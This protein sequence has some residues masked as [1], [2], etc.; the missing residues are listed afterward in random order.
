MKQ[1]GIIANRAGLSKKISR[2]SPFARALYL[3]AIP[4]RDDLGRTDGD[5]ETFKWLNCPSW[6]EPVEE[7]EKAIHEMLKVKLAIRYT[8]NGQCVLEFHKHD[9]FQIFRTDLYRRASYPNKSGEKE[10]LE[11]DKD[12]GKWV[13]RNESKRIGTKRARTEQNRTNKNRT[14][15]Q[16]FETFWQAYPK[17]EGKKAAFRCWKSLLKESIKPSDLL[18]AAENYSAY[19]EKRKFENRYIKLASTF[20]GPDRWYEDFV[21]KTPDDEPFTEPVCATCYKWHTDE[22]PHRDENPAADQRCDSYE[23]GEK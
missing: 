23:R 15:T 17:H 1:G 13:K 10:V 14:Y 7:I 12:A 5:S 8:V 3:V 2:L 9:E 16:E 22:C 6:P 19:C 4:Q 21:R 20:L 11:Y 18:V